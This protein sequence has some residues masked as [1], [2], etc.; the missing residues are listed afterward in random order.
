VTL[1]GRRLGLLLAG[2]VLLAPS[3]GGGTPSSDELARSVTEARDRVD[4]ALED[5]TRADTKDEFLERMDGAAD[6]IGSAAR[7]VEDAGA[8]SGYETEADELVAALDQLAFD[9]RATAD[10]VRQPGFGYLLRG[11]RGLSFES[12]DRV[13]LALVALRRKGIEVTPLERH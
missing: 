5:V 13:N 12:W 1:P 6:L 10:Q 7:H 4:A 11:T 9:V 3:C 8:P 2:V